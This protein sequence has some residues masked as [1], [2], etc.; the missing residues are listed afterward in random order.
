M[1]F[2]KHCWAEVDL[3][4]LTENFRWIH[5][6]VGGDVCCVVKANAYGHGSCAAA[7]ALQAAGAAAFAVS[8]L[9][10]ARELR[11]HGIDKP[12]LI[13]GY[14]DPD[15]ADEL[16]GLHI[17]QAL[18]ST[19]YAEAL[20]TAATTAGCRVEC[21]LKADT[22]MGRIGFAVRTDF[23]AAIRAMEQCY[24]LPGL[25]VTGLFQHFAVADSTEPDKVAYTEQQ[26]DLFARTA[27]RLQADGFDTGVVH[28]ANSAAQLTHPQ[29]RG[30][31]VR[32]GIILY[33]LAPSDQVPVGML[34][35][36]MRL[37]A[38]VTHLK[39]LQPGQSVSYGRTFTA[40]RPMRV[41][42]VSVGYADGYPRLCSNKGVMT[43]HG[44]PAPVLGRVCMDQTIVDVTDIPQVKMGDEVLV[45]GP[46]AA[47][48]ADT[49]ETVADKAGTIS[50]E[51]VCGIS[52]RVPRVYLQQGKRQ[53]LYY[54]L[55]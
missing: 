18:F 43:I 53:V 34:R 21:H 47:P 2:E 55:A 52:R 9:A 36:V 44:K 50:Y 30:N 7:D 5:R 25:K 32:A 39:W 54:D 20:S 28:C 15:F 41:A 49:A 19:Q 51:I 37:K 33:G 22:G 12:I 3:D 48:G 40:G 26:H 17:T 29:W 46:D 6:H 23:E 14:T 42:T 10:E 1:K 27:A 45:F 11:R 8:C 13:L 16:A 31:M 38:V 4:A 35:Q 24:A